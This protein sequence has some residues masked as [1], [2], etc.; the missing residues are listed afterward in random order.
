MKGNVQQILLLI[1]Y[2]VTG[3]SRKMHSDLYLTKWSNLADNQ[4]DSVVC[5]V[6]QSFYTKELT[7]C[8]KNI[9][10]LMFI[11]IQQKKK[12]NH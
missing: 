1:R 12:I 5:S 4:R 11:W 10:Q 8:Y 3:M 7:V 2:Q 6:T 9:H